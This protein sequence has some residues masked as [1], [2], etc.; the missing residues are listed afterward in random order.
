MQRNTANSHSAGQTA[1]QTAETAPKQLIHAFTH[2]LGVHS[3]KTYTNR[4]VNPLPRFRISC[5][6][7]HDLAKGSHSPRQ[8]ASQTAEAVPKSGAAAPYP[9]TAQT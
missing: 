3:N 5:A 6:C 4:L 1:F 9:H 2:H 7:I 8:T